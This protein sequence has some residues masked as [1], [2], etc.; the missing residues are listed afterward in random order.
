MV[1]RAQERNAG[2]MGHSPIAEGGNPPDGGSRETLSPVSLFS[3]GNRKWSQPSRALA[4]KSLSAC[5]SSR[6]SVPHFRA[7]SSSRCFLVVRHPRESSSREE[8]R[9]SSAARE[10]RVSPLP[11]RAR[12]R[13]C[14][15]PGRARFGASVMVYAREGSSGEIVTDVE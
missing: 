5:C 3:G 1:I 2:A 12:S 8:R 14:A 10:G 15:G 11:L 4:G 7:R 13:R 9:E 6:V